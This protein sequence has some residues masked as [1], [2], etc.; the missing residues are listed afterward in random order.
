M[1]LDPALGAQIRLA[2]QATG[3][4]QAMRLRE[5][6]VNLSNAA[7][8]L[9]TDFASGEIE[10]AAY[11]TGLA[12]I[13]T[14]MN[15]LRGAADAAGET[16]EG[17]NDISRRTFTSL[18]QLTSSAIDTKLKVDAEAAKELAAALKSV[19][20]VSKNAHGELQQTGQGITHV[21]YAAMQFTY[22]LQDLTSAQGD[23]ERGL[24][25]TL[26][27]MPLLA[28]SFANVMGVT[29]QT[30]MLWGAGIGV[31][32]VAAMELYRNWDGLNS[33]LGESKTL[34]ESERMEEL[35]KKT[36][37]T[38]D[39]TAQLNK[40]KREQADI[41]ALMRLESKEE[42]DRE[43]IVKEAIGE[44]G[45]DKLRVAVMDAMRQRGLLG[46][47]TAEERARIGAAEA[48]MRAPG[49]DVHARMAQAEKLEQVQAQ[50]AER[51]RKDNEEQIGR[52]MTGAEKD[53]SGLLNLLQG[54]AGVPRS[55]MLALGEAT[56][57]TMQRRREEAVDLKRQLQ[58]VKV[59]REEMKKAVDERSEELTAAGRENEA[60]ARKQ[61]AAAAG[62]VEAQKRIRDMQVQAGVGQ[63][64]P[65]MLKDETEFMAAVSRRVKAGQKD[66]DIQAGL[67][68]V[69]RR[70]L[71][72]Q[73]AQA[74]LVDEIA[75]GVIEKGIAKARA[76]VAAGGDVGREAKAAARGAAAGKREGR[77]D[78][79]A[80]EAALAEQIF[81]SFGGAEGGAN[82]LAAQAAAH[83]AMQAI[84]DGQRFQVAV[85]NGIRQT[86][87]QLEREIGRAHV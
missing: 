54:Q 16:I 11:G 60:L 8:K 61:E 57:A 56:P 50:V 74:N 55:F 69:M 79:A 31:A 28:T 13:G 23:W 15:R 38:A 32:A 39:E 85:V 82:P 33:L 77:E 86:M 18:E 70:R 58:E 34:A 24:M 72:E 68:D 5:A 44:M 9:A 67:G 62:V 21:S 78:R 37:K 30:A 26:N 43:K 46:G 12:T 75:N 29:T 83:R 4:D 64:A 59:E 87:V 47:E 7:A 76:I 80:M 81:A 6:F 63:F 25:A 42:K 84:A 53:P 41:E 17:L 27:N 2:I 73:G 35:G 52:M 45:P 19:D 40:H 3:E 22:T 65:E 49:L 20:T 36:H 66:T 51:I 10:F 1:P 14:H 71:G 48:A